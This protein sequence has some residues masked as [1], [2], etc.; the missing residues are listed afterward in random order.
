MS[1]VVKWSRV[2]V[3]TGLSSSVCSVNSDI[4]LCGLLNSVWRIE[5]N[6]IIW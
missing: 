3:R 5:A 2:V 4:L 6:H 1:R